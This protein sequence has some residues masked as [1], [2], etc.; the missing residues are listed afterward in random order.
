MPAKSLSRCPWALG[1]RERQEPAKCPPELCRCFWKLGRAT[2]PSMKFKES[3]RI[4]I[5]SIITYVA[6]ASCAAGGNLTTG[7]DGGFIDQIVDAA[8]SD[9][10]WEAMTDAFL[11]KAESGVAPTPLDGAADVTSPLNPVKPVKAAESGTRLK[12]VRHVTSD[13]AKQWAYTWWDT[14]R[15]EKCYF[16]NA[17]DGKIRCIPAASVGAQSHYSEATCTQP[18]VLAIRPACSEAKYASLSPATQTCPPT[19]PSLYQLGPRYTGSFYDKFGAQCVAGS[20]LPTYEYY[21]VGQKIA[22][23]EFAEG[24][25][26]IDP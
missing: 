26:Q 10:P 14:T 7:R 25:E 21:E 24:V 18:L 22:P 4:L 17:E 5:G 11:G 12:A 20:P 1:Y 3:L 16:G 13:G 9:S 15:T 23:T 2:S 8:Q 6:V 19:G